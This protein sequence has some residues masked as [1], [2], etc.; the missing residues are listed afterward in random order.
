MGSIERAA[1]IKK[2][3]AAKYGVSTTAIVWAGNR[4]FFVC[5]DGEEHKI[6]VLES[7]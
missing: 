7:R 2:K 5:K 1:K 3:L 4:K 6:I